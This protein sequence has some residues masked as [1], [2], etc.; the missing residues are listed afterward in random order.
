VAFS[1]ERKPRTAKSVMFGFR[2][3]I[4]PP[5]FPKQETQNALVK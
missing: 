4:F 5:A 3:K 2:A 1:E